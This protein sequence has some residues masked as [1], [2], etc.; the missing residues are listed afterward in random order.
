[1]DSNTQYAYSTRNRNDENAA[2]IVG[3]HSFSSNAAQEPPKRRVLGD[4]ANTLSGVIPGLRQIKIGNR[5][6]RI[7]TRSSSMSITQNANSSMQQ[8]S[9][10]A[11]ESHSSHAHA[12]VHSQ[13]F[14]PHPSAASLIPNTSSSSSQISYAQ[15][16]QQIQSQSQPQQR[17]HANSFGGSSQTALFPAIPTQYPDALPSFMA[18]QR[19]AARPSAA[20]LDAEMEDV[21]MTRDDVQKDIDSQDADD[22]IMAAEYVGDIYKYLFDK[23]VRDA[24]DATYMTRQQDINPRMRA[25]TIDWLVEVHAEF[26]MMTDTL[27]LAVYIMDRYLSMTQTNRRQLQLVGATAMM[28]ASKVEEIYCPRVDDFVM[29]CDRAY[30][31]EQ[32][33][34]MEG[35]ML[36]RLGFQVTTST[37]IYFLRRFIKAADGDTRLKHMACYFMELMMLNINMLQYLPSQIAAVALY[38]ALRVIHRSPQWSA[39]L[40]YHTR[41]SEA[42]LQ[43]SVQDLTDIIAGLEKSSLKAVRVKYR[44]PK[45]SEVAKQV[46]L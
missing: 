15:Q 34:D 23:E 25:I 12:H 20:T 10:Y 14:V 4:V 16:Q 5:D 1:M 43:Q 33:L 13:S 41:Y 30:S 38:M 21:N 37:P 39:H 24:V 26:K 45:F 40:E 27:Y 32:V 6:E 35:A 7:R 17:Q 9:T 8:Q 46:T 29:L 3:K 22:I 28:I 31:R 36:N 18:Q 11:H 44:S 19:C 2:P 42:A